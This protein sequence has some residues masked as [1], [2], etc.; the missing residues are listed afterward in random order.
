MK[1]SGQNSTYKKIV[2]VTIAISLLVL[3]FFYYLP[4]I[5]WFPPPGISVK[6]QA[7]FNSINACLELFKLENNGYP[8]SSALDIVGQPYCGAMKLCEAMMGQDLLGFHPDSVFRADGMDDTGKQNL[9]LSTTDNLKAR[10]GRLLQLD[11]ANVF[12]LADIYG[13]GNTGPFAEDVLVLCDTYQHRHWTGI[14]AGMPILYYKAD[15]SKT[16]HDVSEPNNP[17]NIYNYKDNHALLS[18]GVPGK[19]NK[20]HPLFT[21]PKIFYEMTKNRNISTRSKP[22][23][24]DS[25]ILISAGK[26]GLYGTPD[27]I[28][29]FPK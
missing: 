1:K 3:L 9:Y 23:W 7:Q 8:S 15:M 10:K 16:A 21:N 12:K 4:H 22:N 29:N 28:V 2:I 27:D 5:N 20:K 18:L 11:D 24:E 17:E 6:Q 14:K 26:D 13:L 19:P 25:F